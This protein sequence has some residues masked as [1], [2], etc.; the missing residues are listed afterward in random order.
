MGCERAIWAIRVGMPVLGER[1]LDNLERQGREARDEGRGRQWT[2]DNQTGGIGAQPL[3]WYLKAYLQHLQGNEDAARV[4]LQRAADLP[5]NNN[6]PTH[7]EWVR[8]LH[9]A[10]Q[11]NTED[12]QPHAYLAPLEYWLTQTNQAVQHWETLLRHKVNGDSGVP[13]GLAMAL[14]EDRSD[15]GSAAKILAEALAQNPDQERLYLVLDDVLVED[16]DVEA[17]ATWQARARQK[18][19]PTDFLMERQCHLLVN[20]QRWREVV[21]L[22]SEHKFGPSHGLYIRRRMWLLAHHRLALQCLEGGDFAK[23][24]EYGLAGARPPIT[25]GEDDMTMPF[26]SPVLLAAAEACEKMGR[27]AEAKQLL[28][29]ALS[30][31]AAGHMHPPYTEIHRARVLLKLGKRAAAEKLLQEILA[32]VLP[33]LNDTRPGLSKAHFHFMYGLVLQTQGRHEQARHHFAQADQLGLQWA[34]LVGYGV[35]WGFN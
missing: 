27:K 12:L 1:I 34:N 31:A 7:P 4:S 20:Q 19:G 21:E 18:C 25:L 29:Q 2:A 35:Q 16:Q 33:R 24:Y 22:L 30:L 10:L 28:Q 15:R 32:E 13:Y 26:A 17:R 23:A 5:R 6:R 14:W 3:L 8:V 9:W 11:T